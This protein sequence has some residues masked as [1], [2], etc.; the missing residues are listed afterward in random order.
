MWCATSSKKELWSYEQ[1]FACRI[2]VVAALLF[3]GLCSS[4][5]DP[6]AASK[7]ISD[8]DALYSQ[9]T[10]KTG[11]QPALDLYEKALTE[12]PSSAEA[13][14]KAARACYWIADHAVSKKEKISTFENGITFAQKAIAL[15]PQSL[16]AHFWLGGLYG[17]YGEAKGILKSLALVKPIRVEMQTIIGLNDRYQGGGGYRVL[18]IVDYKVPG[19]AGGNKKRSFEELIKALSIDP[20]NPFNQFYIAEYFSMTGEKQQSLEHLQQLQTLKASADVDQPDLLD[21]QAKGKTLT[22]KIR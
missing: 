8:A 21:I 5:A 4:W 3:F 19:F 2:L 6:Q 7:F 13:C 16:D 11:A 17:S 10:E 14:W 1:T 22:E 9:R 12:N 20:M 18:G 15:D